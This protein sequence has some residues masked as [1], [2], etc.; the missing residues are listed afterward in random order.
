[1]LGKEEIKAALGEL[2]DERRSVNE[3]KHKI[4]HAF[5]ERLMIRAEK[6]EALFEKAKGTFVGG[7]AL[8]TLTGVAWIGNLI[9][10][11]WKR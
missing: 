5:V 10:E 9:I 8:A 11:A 6:R 1:M 2:L 4:H 7:L 3:P